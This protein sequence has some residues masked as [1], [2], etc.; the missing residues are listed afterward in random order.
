MFKRNLTPLIESAAKSF[1]VMALVGPRQSGKTTLLRALFPEYKYVSLESPDT[2]LQIKEDPRSY[3]TL[4]ESPGFIL[5]EAQNFEDLFSY[6]QEIVD[7]PNNKKKYILS[8]SQ[9]FLLSEKIS[10]SLAGRVA[11]LELLSLNLT[12]YLSHPKFTKPA[13]FD[14]LFY[15]TYP[16]IYHESLDAGLWYS[17]YLKTYVERDIRQ[18]VNVQDLTQFQLFIKMCASRHAQ[19][20]NLQSLGSDCG[21]SQS[22][23]QRWISALE[24]SYLIFTLK[25]YFRNFNKRLVKAPKLYF[26][27]PGIVCHLLGIESPEHLSVHSNRGAIFEGYVI[28]EVFK[29]S[30]SMIRPPSFYYW[31]DKN[32]LEVD[33]IIDR[34]QSIHGIEIKSSTTALPEFSHNL[35]KWGEISNSELSVVYGGEDDLNISGVPYI[36]WQ[37]VNSLILPSQRT[38]K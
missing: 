25:P 4:S 9:N 10:Q 2:L 29:L 17:S 22:T 5:D 30:K 26:Y 36:S 14:Y 13:L 6:L 28:S 11:I 3:L 20:L 18:I 32:K 23:A 24:A 1:P 33:L 7:D 19:E 31:R 16:R 35:K 38:A 15:G 12:E 27:D 37:N 34:P 21:I 8:G